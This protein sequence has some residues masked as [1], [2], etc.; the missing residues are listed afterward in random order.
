VNETIAVGLI[1]VA[2]LVTLPFSVFW[3]A[4]LGRYGYL[5]GEQA[6]D[7]DKAHGRI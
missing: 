7:R 6:F 3:A 2:V 4:K 5:L 1:V